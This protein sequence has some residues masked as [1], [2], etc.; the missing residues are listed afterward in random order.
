MQS[1]VELSPQLLAESCAERMYERDVATRS[2]GIVI[3][4]VMPGEAV[5]SM[6]VSDVMIQGHGSCH[7]G[8]IFTLADSAFAIACNTYNTVTVGQACTID[9]IAPAKLGDRLNATAKELSRGKRTGV[10]D[11]SIVNQRDKLLATFRGRSYQVQGVLMDERE[12][13]SKAAEYLVWCNE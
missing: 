8:Y 7:G 10:Y 3:D 6:L 13:Q 9:Y 1:T 12:L 11:V 4:A 5:L 2:L